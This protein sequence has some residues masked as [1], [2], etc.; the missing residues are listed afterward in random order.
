MGL[1]VR[2]FSQ[3]TPAVGLQFLAKISMRT[4]IPVKNG[5]RQCR[6]HSR[7]CIQCCGLSKLLTTLYK[8]VLQSLSFQRFAKSDFLYRHWHDVNKK[9]SYIRNV[10]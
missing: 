9:L 3:P 2:T 4:C 5:L 7:F 8:P 6:L 1:R 10:S